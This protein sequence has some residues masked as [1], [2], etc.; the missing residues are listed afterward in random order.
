MQ[1]IIMIPHHSIIAN[2]LQW[3]AFQQRGDDAQTPPAET[4]LSVLPYSH[5]YSLILIGH[6]G[7]YRGDSAIVFPSFAVEPV[8]RAIERH[9]I[10]TLWTVPPML[11]ALLR[12]P[13]VTGRYR[14]DSVRR[15]FTGATNLTPDTIEALRALLPGTRFGQGYGQTESAVVV[16]FQHEDDWMLGSV[17]HLLPGVQARLVD[18]HG[19]HVS[20]RLGA[21]GE[22]VLKAPGRMLG[23]WGD[24]DATREAFTED[25]WLRT[26][27]LMEFRESDKGHENLFMI[28]RV[29]QVIKVMV[30]CL[31][32][33]TVHMCVVLLCLI[34]NLRIV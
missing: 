21:R 32:N 11:V 7:I 15:T 2:T 18:E 24:E 8:C 4:A 27:D 19:Q 5:S 17:G 29:K 6:M 26:G 9:R 28:D 3:I 14:L 22:L 10:E 20:G 25:G 34:F 30:S 1:K 23:Y 13:H 33:N 12:S 16:S 31:Y